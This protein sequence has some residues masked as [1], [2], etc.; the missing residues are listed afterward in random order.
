MII[1]VGS[2]G[3]TII[4]NTTFP[5]NIDNVVLYLNGTSRDICTRRHAYYAFC[6]LQ[7]FLRASE[8][9][10]T[11]PGAIMMEENHGVF[12]EPHTPPSVEQ[13]Y[14][15]AIAM[16]TFVNHTQPSTI[17]PPIS[18]AARFSLA[19]VFT[20]LFALLFL[21]ISVQLCLILYFGHRR[22]SYQSVFLF[23]YLF[24]AALRTTLFSFYF[25]DS[26]TLNHLHSFFKWLLFALPIYLQ[27]LTLSLLT[28]YLAKVSLSR[29]M[30]R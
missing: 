11:D 1:L 10:R 4:K 13:K 7:R 2:L 12:A 19:I 22:L 28:L 14:G 23:I 25:N 6:Q 27:F 20:S 30:S 5:R 18:D 17:F 15:G 16:Y 24:W 29:L 21:M 8:C 9:C 26:S 3:P